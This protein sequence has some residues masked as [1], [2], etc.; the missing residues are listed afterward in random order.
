[1]ENDDHNNSTINLD[2]SE[3]L[4]STKHDSSVLEI[5]S[6][7]SQNDDIIVVED[8]SDGDTINIKDDKPNFCARDDED[9]LADRNV[10]VCSSSD[11]GISQDT[12]EEHYVTSVQS[13]FQLSVNPGENTNS[14]VD[15][16]EASQL[17]S[18][19]NTTHYNDVSQIPSSTNTTAAGDLSHIEALK[20]ELSNHPMKMSELM[21]EGLGEV[22]H[23]VGEKD[24]LTSEVN[25]ELYNSII[26]SA[27]KSALN[28]DD[29]YNLEEV[30]NACLTLSVNDDN[31]IVKKID[32]SNNSESEKQVMEKTVTQN[33][34]K[35]VLLNGETESSP[36]KR[37]SEEEALS[38]SLNEVSI[39]KDDVLAA[40]SV[41]EGSILESSDGEKTDIEDNDEDS[42]SDMMRI[43]TG[44][45]PKRQRISDPDLPKTVQVLYS[46]K[47]GA[48]V[49]LI[50]TAHF[51]KESCEDVAKV[52]EGVQPDIV[53]I[54]L[55]KARTNMLHLDDETI[56]EEAKNLNFEKS[57]DIIKQQGAVQGGMYLA[58]LSM[59]AHLTR[60]LGMAPGGEF[61]RAFSEAQKVP[62]CMV[63]LG[64]R[65]IGITLKRALQALSTWQKIKLGYNI[66]IT[67]MDKITPE[68]VE[69][70]KERDL[71]E[72]MLAEMAGEFPALSRVFVSER[73]IFLSHS[74]QMAADAIPVHAIAPGG[75]LLEGFS[76][77]VVVG[78]VGIGHVPGIVNNWGTVKKEDIREIVKIEPP[79]KMQIAVKFAFKTAFLGGCLYGAYR[80]GRI[81][82]SRFLLSR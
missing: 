60:E 58:L 22:D 59:S 9:D 16:C 81:P 17:L 75:G 69:K 15:T 44:L 50:G 36:K 3:V 23:D 38:N 13:P 30:T 64:D 6:S 25:D 28:D 72:N 54:E 12:T 66:L 26:A 79:S 56:L 49:Y 73:D 82:V 14:S 68:E 70:C 63:H 35:A 32:L 19:A 43:P 33:E 20:N 46:A 51:S 39:N 41:I 77:P 57:M 65:P 55:C 48:K 37:K 1:M 80:I 74:L 52:I 40:V 24:M 47:S 2:D 42:E 29:D 62:G 4:S 7:S 78:V 5:S 27:T 8:E 11:E 34:G 53:M 71:L 10:E 21:S 67:S 31:V 45:P 76:P 61:R 18:S